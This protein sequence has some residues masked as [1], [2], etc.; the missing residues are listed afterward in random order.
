M[1]SKPDD[2]KLDIS[3]LKQLSCFACG[4]TDSYSN[5]NWRHI[6]AGDYPTAMLTKQMGLFT[7]WRGYSLPLYTANR[8]YEMKP[9]FKEYERLFYLAIQKSSINSITQ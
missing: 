9:S 6:T 4:K 3:S 8:E 1:F 2:I 7:N 5:K